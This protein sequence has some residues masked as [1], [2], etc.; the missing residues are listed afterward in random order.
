MLSASISPERIL[1][2]LKRANLDKGWIAAV[3]DRNGIIVARSTDFPD[4]VG[5]PL[6]KEL[7]EASKEHAGLWHAIGYRERAG[8]AR[9]R[10]FAAGGLA[11]LDQRARS[12]CQPGDHPFLDL[13]GDAGRELH[14]AVGASRLS[15]RTQDRRSRAQLVDGAGALGRG[16]LVRPGRFLYPARY[17]PSA[18]PR[19]RASKT[20]QYMEQSLRESEDRLRLALAP[21]TRARGTGISRRATSPG[22]PA[23]ARIVGARARRPRHPRDLSSPALDQQDREPTLAAIDK[24][25]ELATAR[26]SIDVEHRV[27][28]KRTGSSAGSARRAARTLPTARRCA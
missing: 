6:A 11:H 22:I 20:R 14:A 24:A 13:R 3:A 4:Y 25:Q 8:A 5:N 1:E 23:H 28:G 27:I 17:P 18:T 21:P 2:I 10:L 26:S 12:D 7:W 15:I 19:S 9:E 16:E